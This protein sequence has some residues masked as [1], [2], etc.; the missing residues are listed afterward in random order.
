MVTWPNGEK[1]FIEDV[2]AN[3]VVHLKEGTL[4]KKVVTSI[5]DI[6]KLKA[7]IYPNPFTDYL[8]IGFEEPIYGRAEFQLTDAAGRKVFHHGWEIAKTMNLDIDLSSS[9]RLLNSGLYFYTLTTS[10][11][12]ATGSVLKR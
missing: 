6:Q 12:L 10:A 1:E 7:N 9:N 3:Q 2:Q 11:G 8:S 5:T 4:R